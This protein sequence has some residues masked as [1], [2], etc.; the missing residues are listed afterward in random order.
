[1]TRHLGSKFVSLLFWAA[2]YAVRDVHT[3]A[4]FL[5]LLLQGLSIDSTSVRGASSDLAAGCQGSKYTI[6]DATTLQTFIILISEPLGSMSGTSSHV[7]MVDVVECG[8][9]SLRPSFVVIGRILI[10]PLSSNSSGSAQ[11]E[12]IDCILFATLG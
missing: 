1:M 3:K 6:R 11:T 12:V 10:P 7:G 4:D 9:S 5:S 8:S 2:E